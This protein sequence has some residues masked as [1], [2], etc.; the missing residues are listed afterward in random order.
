MKQLCI[1]FLFFLTNCSHTDE[2][3]VKFSVTGTTIAAN[4]EYTIIDNSTRLENV[5]LPWEFEFKFR[6]NEHEKYYVS[7]SAEKITGDNSTIILEITGDGQ[8]L[9]Y[10]AFSGPYEIGFIQA[11]IG[12]EGYSD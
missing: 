8:K 9:N 6:S 3:I 12:L 1:L 10:S 2:E 5:S 4:I 7:L 11:M